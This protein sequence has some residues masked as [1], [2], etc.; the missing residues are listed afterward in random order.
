MDSPTTKDYL[1]AAACD[2]ISMPESGSLMLTGLRADVIFFKDLFDKIGVRAD[3]LRMGDFKSAAEP[4]TRSSMSKES[5]QQLETVLDD[6][7]AKEIV[8]HIAHARTQQKLTEDQVK[9][10]IDEGPYT[11]RAA[12]AARLIDRPAPTDAS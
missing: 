6:F 9:Q 5:R 12:K 1:V 7:Y 11:T 10:L 4:Y 8:A 3:M 2:E